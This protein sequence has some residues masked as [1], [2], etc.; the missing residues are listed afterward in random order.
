MTLLRRILRE[1]V[2]SGQPVL[3]GHLEG[4][5]GCPLNTGLTV[6]CTQFCSETEN[7]EPQMKTKHVTWSFLPSAVNVIL[8]ISILSFLNRSLLKFR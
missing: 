2:F 4:S 8:N 3:S 7:S 6:H 5:R 1:P